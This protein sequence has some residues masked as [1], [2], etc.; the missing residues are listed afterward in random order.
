M[1]KRKSTRKLTD[2]QRK[3]IEG[4][5]EGKTGHQAALNAGYSPKNPDQSAYQAMK[6]IG[7]RMREVMDRLGLT[8]EQLIQKHLVPLLEARETKFFAFRKTVAVPATKKRKEAVKIV[9]VIDTREV[10]ALGIRVSALDMAF[11]LRGDY[12]PR[13]LEIDPDTP[14]P[15]RTIDVSDVSDIPRHG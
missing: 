3:L 10:E 13:Q 12:A 9:Q 2:R 7:E 4:I 6:N 14:I 11:K 15:V 1:A 8:D 5:V